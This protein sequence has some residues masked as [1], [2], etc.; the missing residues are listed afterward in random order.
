MSSAGAVQ[1]VELSEANELLDNCRNL[2]F[3]DLI[4]VR[5]EDANLTRSRS[6][7]IER[8]SLER[9]LDSSRSWLSDAT[10]RA[11]VRL[12][13]LKKASSAELPVKIRYQF[14][15]RP[16]QGL[17]DLADLILADEDQR[18]EIRLRQTPASTQ[19]TDSSPKRVAH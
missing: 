8:C 9:C 16:T 14:G 2:L 19:I 7:P 1:M 6:E 15:S 17:L 4:V 5:P 11:K 13:R 10:L 18:S 3:A 12:E